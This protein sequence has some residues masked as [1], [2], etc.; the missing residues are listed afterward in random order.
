M[1]LPGIASRRRV[2][3]LMVFLL[4]GGAGV[5][6]LLQLGVDFFPEA[7]LGII[8]VVTALPGASPE[9]VEDLVSRPLEDAV[10]GVESVESVES[11][12]G[13]SVSV[14]TVEISS[15]AD[16]DQVEDDIR[17]AVDLVG[18]ELPEEAGEPLQLSL[19]SDMKPLAIVGFSSSSMTSSE[20]RRMVDDEILPVLARVEGVASAG[21]SGGEVRQVNVQADPVLL[22]LRGIPL[23]QVYGALAAAGRD[24]PGGEIE[25]EG[26]EVS[27]SIRSGFHHLEDIRSLAV[28]SHGGVPVRLRDVATVERGFREHSSTYR[29]DGENSVTVVFRKSADA[30][31]VNTCAALL[32]EVER[33][34]GDYSG[35]LDMEVVYNQADFVKSSMSSLVQTAIQAVLLAAAVLLVFLGSAGSAGIVSISMPLSFISTFGAMHLLGIDLNVMSLAGLSISIGMIVDNSVVV[36]EN[37]NRLRRDGM[38]P[39]EGSVRGAAQVGMAVAASTLTTMA[40]FI[41]MLFVTGLTGQ[42]FRD[43]SITIASALLISLFVSQ[44]LIPLAA[45]LHRGLVRDRSGR[46]PLGRVQAW[47]NRLE[48]RYS[49]LVSRAVSRRL[50]FSAPVVVLFVLAV[51]A[52]R[53]VPTSFL[54]EVPEGLMDVEASLPLGTGLGVTDSVAMTL[55][56]SLLAVMEPGDLRHMTTHVGRGS[57]IWAAFGSDAASRINV[58]LYFADPSGLTVS[59]AGYEERVRNVLE[60]FPGLE[61]TVTSGMPLGNEYPVQVVVYGTDLD[62]LRAVGDRVRQSL[63]GIPGTTDHVTSLDEWVDRIELVPYREALASRGL[64][65]GTVSGELAMGMLGVDAATFDS[66]GVELD[67]NLRYDAASRSS[68][69]R[70]A[71]I[72]VAGA[73]LAA[74]GELSMDRVPR[75]IWRRDRSRAVSVSCKIEGRALGDVGGDVRDEMGSLDIGGRRWEL[76]G[77]LP[78]Q[79]EAFT[80]MGLAIAAAVVLVYMVMASQFESLLE[81]FILILEIPLAMIGVVLVHWALGM[82]LGLTSLVGILMLAGI[83]V[84]NGIV[85]VDFANQLRRERGGSARDAITEAAS[86][87]L[88]PILMTAGTTCLALLPLAVSSSVSAVLWSPMALTVIGGMLVATPLTLLILPILYVS[89]DR[90]RR[91]AGGE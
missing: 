65:P 23:T 39:V 62:S 47:L 10:S 75:S 9:E 18:Q 76:L 49:D 50:A 28:G 34:R 21:I 87:R 20:L 29:L 36:L 31:T 43:L 63:E 26:A 2:T 52:A 15:G 44:T 48:G 42:I 90:L 38:S 30:N 12:S 71:G 81:P 17:E 66:G 24:R 70:V 56:D 80:S 53:T 74:W 78:D 88:K 14:V 82:T 41:P 40:V 7:D 58:S 6:G 85:F 19:E 3:F 22:W 4:M 79:R 60:T 46:S 67:V 13:G 25:S 57:G 32:E 5:F 16:I 89:I 51:L 72:P 37:I 35:T 55:E 33:V 27:L 77:D 64:G 1:S 54:P 8:M 11:E 68:W 84:N 45:G 86:K 61:H 69:E 91:K 59:M 83:V 73:P